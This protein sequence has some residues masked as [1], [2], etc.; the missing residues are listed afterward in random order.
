MR[1]AEDT[2][3]KSIAALRRSYRDI[4]ERSQC[5][6]DIIMGMTSMIA[7]IQKKKIASY[8]ST[9]VLSHSATYVDA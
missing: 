7:A 1:T 6:T 9:V 3:R 4:C 8:V 5:Y 2:L